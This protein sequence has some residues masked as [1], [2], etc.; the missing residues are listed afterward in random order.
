VENTA[1]YRRA[2]C[3]DRETLPSR[4]QQQTNGLSAEQVVDDYALAR[5]DYRVRELTSQFD[6]SE[7]EKEDLRHDMVVELLS[8]FKRFDPDKATRETFINRVLD[9]FVKHAIRVRCTRQRRACDSPIGFDDIAPG[10]ESAV[11]DTRSGQLNEQGLCE[12]RLDLRAAIARM[13]ERLQRVCRLLMTFN[14]T[15]T[16]RKLGICRQSIYRNIREIRGRLIRAGLGIS[17]KGATDSPQL[18][19]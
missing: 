13:P 8:A 15:E 17:E 5:I 6:L 9:K 16:A 3:P 7:D 18:Q 2:V 10:Y 1:F 4:P 11:N 12:L 14:P 19:M